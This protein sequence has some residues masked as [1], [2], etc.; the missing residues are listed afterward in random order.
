VRSSSPRLERGSCAWTFLALGL[1]LAL[2]TGFEADAAGAHPAYYG[3]RVVS[4]PQVVIVNWGSLVDANVA[5]GMAGFYSTSLQSP[6]LDWLSEYSTVGLTGLTDSLAGSKQRIGR[7][8]FVGA[9]TIAAPAQ[10]TVANTDVLMLLQAEIGVGDLPAPTLDAEGNANTVYVVNFP[11]GVTL[12]SYGGTS[13]AAPPLG[14]CGTTDTMTVNNLSVGVGL[15]PDQS[16]A[17]PCTGLCGTD[18]AYFN[19]ATEVHAHVLL[20]LVTNLEYGLWNAAGTGTVARPVAW[21]NLGAEHQV[22]D[23]CTGLP[24]DVGGYTVEMGWSN[25]QGACVSS[26]ASALPVCSSSTTYCRQCSS[27][28]VGQ[29]AGCTGGTAACETDNTNAAF[30]ECVQCTSGT[31]CAGTT[32]VC[33]K[34]GTTNDTCRAC[35]GDGECTTNPAGTHCLT[36]G[37]CGPAPSSGSSS[38]CTATGGAPSAVAALLALLAFVLR[39][40]SLTA[41]RQ[42]GRRGPTGLRKG[43]GPRRA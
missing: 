39:R 7:G 17:S 37:A 8:N 35:D 12:L 6:Y 2:G 20:N 23:L 31:T 38:G 26:A 4:N 33:A 24:A 41:Q 5:N 15:I 21:Y 18:T 29:D 40:A 28:D 10:T 3:G 25:A 43:G 30:V 32:P 19:N 13:C 16:P 27:T 9:Y 22:A 1:G 14:F 11:P 42:T 36:S 34:G